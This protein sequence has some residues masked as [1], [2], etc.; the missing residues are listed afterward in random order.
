MLL[1]Q[2]RAKR[3]DSQRYVRTGSTEKCLGCP[4]HWRGIYDD[5]GRLIVVMCHNMDL[6]DSWEH[7]ANPQYPA[8]FS[9]LGI[10]IGMNYIIYSMTH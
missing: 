3:R 1:L 7:A 2:H 4:A 6:G 10:R 8:K 5:F 9:D